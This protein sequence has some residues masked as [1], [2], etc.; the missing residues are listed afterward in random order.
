MRVSRLL[1]GMVLAAAAAVPARACP[2]FP[3]AVERA[4]HQYVALMQSRAAQVTAESNYAGTPGA[5]DAYLAVPSRPGDAGPRGL[6]FYLRDGDA[7][8]GYYRSTDRWNL[9]EFRIPVP[10]RELSASIEATVA[11]VAESAAPLERRARLR[12]QG[13]DDGDAQPVSRGAAPL[14]GPRGPDPAPLLARLGGLLF[15]PG[16]RDEIS[17]LSSLTIVPAVNIGIVPFAALDP[18]GDGVPLV[19]TTALN[20]EASLGDVLSGRLFALAGGMVPQAIAGD[21]D[22]SGDPQWIFPR[23]PGAAREARAIAERFGTVA[24]IGPDATVAEVLPRMQAAQYVHIAAHG[25]SSA[26]DPVD[27]S[28]LALSGGRLTAR[29]IQSLRLDHPAL[30]TLSACQTGLGGRLDAGIVGLARGFILAGASSVLASLWN[31]DDDATAYIMLR[32]VEHLSTYPPAEALRRAQGEARSRWSDPAKWAAF[33]MF[34]SRIVTL[35]QAAPREGE[36]VGVAFS[37]QRDGQSV[38]LDA[39]AATRVGDGDVL[40]ARVSNTTHRPLDMV[41]N[42]TD[43]D[44]TSTQVMRQRLAPGEI[45]DEPVLMFSETTRGREYLLAEFA[46]PAGTSRGAAPGGDAGPQSTLHG[47]GLG[48]LPDQE[49]TRTMTPLARMLRLGGIEALAASAPRKGIA[50]ILELAA[51]DAAGRDTLELLPSPDGARRGVRVL[52]FEVSGGEFEQ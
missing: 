14:T 39:R 23:L 27:G 32:Y 8:C 3:E 9:V 49:Q 43:A 52:E 35:P 25:Y 48:E 11:A 41:L 4:G 50:G 15:P 37:L 13:G 16:I 5:I 34:G 40:A 10:A 24:V 19:E 33:M 42:Y 47:P 20:V 12:A 29:S 36:P 6:V 1:A 46:A 45:F 2:A 17:L 44:G 28:F 38:V 21:P 31:V 51:A 30:V 7:V 22:A 26:D 18:N